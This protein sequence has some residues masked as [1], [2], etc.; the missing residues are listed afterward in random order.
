[1]KG[2]LSLIFVFVLLTVACGSG[3]VAP[4]ADTVT[5]APQSTSQT[6]LPTVVADPTCEQFLCLSNTF[7]LLEAQNRP[8]EDNVL[9]LF[10]VAVDADRNLAYVAGILTSHIAILDTTNNQWLGTIDSGLVGLAQKYL[11]V[12]PVSN[13]LYVM[14][15]SH[16]QVWRINL[17]DQSR[18]G[19]VTIPF[20][21]GQAAVD[22]QRGRLYL[23]SY[24]LPG[25]FA[26]GGEPFGLLYSSEAMG[27]NTGEL[28]YDSQADKLY[29][30]DSMTEEG[31]RQ[32]HVF[33]PAGA[34]LSE[35][36]SYQVLPGPRSR[37]LGWDGQ[38]QRFMVATPRHV[39]LLNRDGSQ[40]TSFPLPAGFEIAQVSYDTSHQKIVVLALELPTAGQVTA[41][42]AHLLVFEASNGQ[43]VH[44]LAFGLKPR[45]FILVG[46][47]LYIPNG[48]ASV[49]W[50]VDTASYDSITPLR[51]G[52]SLEQVVVAQDG[53]LYLS[54]RLGGGYLLAYDPT[55]G[56]WESF[57]AGVW[58]IPLRGDPAGTHLFALNAWDSTLSVFDIQAG[59]DL[60]GTI[61]LGLPA[62][63]TDRLPDLTIDATN[64]LAYAAYP[65][66]GQIAVVDW[67]NLTPLTVITVA[68]FPAG[69]DGGGPGNLQ[70]AVN[71]AANLLFA[72]W[73]NGHRLAIYDGHNGYALLGEVNLQGLDWQ[74]MVGAG[75]ADQ[76]FFD[77]GRGLL[78]V[79]PFELD[80][81]TG[82]P[83]G[84]VMAQGQRIFA[85]DTQN[86]LLWADQSEDQGLQQ[87]NTIVAL[88]RD[89]L[90]LRQ[91][92]TLPTLTTI[93]P[94]YAL[95]LAHNRLLVGDLSTA[96][97]QIYQIGE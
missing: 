4:P 92:Y 77:Q 6:Y 42:H 32:I 82:Q 17:N 66:F 12:D 1:M 86:N 47:D 54:S 37:W 65:E 36:I 80:G 40:A 15:A 68:G 48:D 69:D 79:G 95:D 62:G 72:F 5:A 71:E 87:A 94:T 13:F 84:R 38:Q 22:S 45:R 39:F 85:V 73:A 20:S 81:Q 50:H 35:Q 52:D 26:Y 19:P 10:S 70:V 64:Q 8:L 63:S 97:L 59:H 33:D 67:A 44:D 49:V 16:Q 58:P 75:G 57:T 11:Q 7:D 93:T 23:T 61:P 9:K 83:T 2:L 91:S 18:S 14:D 27:Q 34:S 78:Y 96:T 30:L 56:G 89:T 88:D 25:F 28:I 41:T 60:V 90:S 55:S 29:I 31:E 3:R 21:N 24:E 46:N 43:P 76:L 74:R 51:L 53:T